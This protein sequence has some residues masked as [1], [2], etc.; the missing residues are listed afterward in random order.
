MK[1]VIGLG[2]PGEKYANTRHNLGFQVV[3]ELARRYPVE[4]QTAKYDAVIGHIRMAGEKAL[5]VKPLT[6]MNLSGNAVFPIMRYYKITN[7]D[8]IVIYDDMDLPVGQIRIRETGGAGGHKGML[9]IISRLGG[10]DFPR[11][12]IGIDRPPDDTIDWVLGRIRPEEQLLLGPALQRAADAVETWVKKDIT[13]A[14]NEF[15]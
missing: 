15:N 8:L 9:S 4:K 6:F 11:L 2:N 12:R 3:G 1:L 14:M 5:L 7:K 10:Q 13:A